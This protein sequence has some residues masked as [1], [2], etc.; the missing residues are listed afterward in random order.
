M[1][2]AIFRI[3]SRTVQYGY[4]EVT[5]PGADASTNPESLAA[6]YVN[7]VYAFQKEEEA[8]IR[9]LSEGRSEPDPRDSIADPVAAAAE[10]IKE[11]LG[12]TEVEEYD[13]ATEAKEDAQARSKAAYDAAY[14]AP[15][16]GPEPAPWNSTVA[17][18]AKPWE[19]G[20]KPVQTVQLSDE[21]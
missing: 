6:Q 20:S 15:N 3:P 16:D 21:W 17:P 2:D 13:S 9:R 5:V 7:Y 4:V 10:A 8:T 11:H 19:T 1:A 14:S 12:A 18:K